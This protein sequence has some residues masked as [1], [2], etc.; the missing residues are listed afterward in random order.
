MSDARRL[1]AGHGCAGALAVSITAAPVAGDELDESE[2]PFS[3]T[4]AKC[5]WLAGRFPPEGLCGERMRPDMA[6]LRSAAANGHAFAAFR[7]GQWHASGNWGVEQNDAMAYRWFRRAAEGGV[8][9]AQLRLARA[10][11]FGRLGLQRDV[12]KAIHYY[13]LAVEDG[14]YPDLEDRL[15]LLRSKLP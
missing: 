5:Y 14:L 2:S 11:E 6:M 4:G 15:T 3:V 9:A 13:E 1:R 12:V 7:L 8:R 10:Y